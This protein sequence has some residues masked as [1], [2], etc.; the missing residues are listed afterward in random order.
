M[1]Y[2]RDNKRTIFLSLDSYRTYEHIY[3]ILAVARMKMREG[4][5]V[6]VQFVD[7]KKCFDKQRLKDTLHAAGL[8]GV[9]GKQLRVMESLHDNTVINIVGDPTERK[10]VIKS[11]NIQRATFMLI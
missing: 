2:G 10:E 7:V 4:K 11:L 5:G 1:D 6:I 9:S 3:T 8:A